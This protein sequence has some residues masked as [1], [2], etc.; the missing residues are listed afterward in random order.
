[1]LLSMQIRVHPSP[2]EVAADAARRVASHLTEGGGSATFG[3][4]GGS[5]PVA[6]YRRLRDEPVPWERVTCWPSDE[7][8][9]SLDHPDSNT[10]MAMRELTDHVAAPVLAPDTSLATAAAAASEYE[11]LLL[12]ALS[13]GT[14]LEPDVVLLGMGADGHT[15]SL[16]PGTAALDVDTPGY[17]A[18]WVDAQDAWRLTATVALLHAARH[19]ILVVTGESKAAMVRRILVDGDPLPTQRVADGA[20]DVTWLLDRAAAAALE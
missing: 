18:N 4:A 7:R 6:T 15:A 16:F 9:V 14:V 11:D 10:A 5:T 17:V 12:P 13:R 19:L 1:M 2:D 8:W 3:L 20:A